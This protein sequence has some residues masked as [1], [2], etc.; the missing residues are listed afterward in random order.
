MR[1]GLL[2]LGAA[3][4]I[5]SADWTV[6]LPPRFTGIDPQE[7]AVSTEVG[8]IGR[9]FGDVEG[10][11]T[12]EGLPAGVLL[13]TPTGITVRGSV[14]ATPGG[15]DEAVPVVVSTARST[16]GP[17]PSRSCEGSSLPRI[18]RVTSMSRWRTPMDRDPRT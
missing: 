8:I 2:V 11:V 15:E 6:V 16:V 13:W 4:V 5:C 14:I 10:T 18:A 7:A 9:G 17:F 12:F 3:A 1:A